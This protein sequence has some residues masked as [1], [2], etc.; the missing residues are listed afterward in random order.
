MITG[1]LVG[2]D[3]INQMA[4]N[5]GAETRHQNR[6]IKTIASIFLEGQTSQ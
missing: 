2:S 4:Q 1:D 3:L 6:N 5:T